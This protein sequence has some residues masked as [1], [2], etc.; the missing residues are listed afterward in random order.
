VPDR[1]PPI[2]K[3]IQYI[4]APYCDTANKW[5]LIFL[6]GETFSIF[7][8]FGKRLLI[9][10]RFGKKRIESFTW[11]DGFIGLTFVGPFPYRIEC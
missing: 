4:G 7:P 10:A 5:R 6:S 11:F 9:R 1:L 8:E 3:S 2:L